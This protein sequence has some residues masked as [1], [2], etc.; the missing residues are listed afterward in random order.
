MTVLPRLNRRL[1]LEDPQRLPDNVGG[2]VTA[3]VSLGVHWANIAPSTGRERADGGGPVSAVSYKITVRGSQLGSPSRPKPEQRFRDGA[4][5]F[6][7][8]AVTEADVTGMYLLCFAD[9]EVVA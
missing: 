8:R 1:T 7:I 4:R 3:W 5:I 6:T 9:E 2:F